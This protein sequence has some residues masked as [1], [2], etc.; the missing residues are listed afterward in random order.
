MLRVYTQAVIT[1]VQIGRVPLQN[2][3][4]NK[5]IVVTAPVPRPINQVVTAVL[6]DR[7]QAHDMAVDVRETSHALARSYPA[8][9]AKK[10]KLSVKLELLRRA[11]AKDAAA[12]AY[13]TKREW[14]GYAKCLEVVA[15]E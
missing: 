2:K 8:Q 4:R 6:I 1:Y 13:A 5:K 10:V 9:T 15:A 11:K 7:H 14:P 3:A 12:M